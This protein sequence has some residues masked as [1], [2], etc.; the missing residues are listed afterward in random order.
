MP[1]FFDGGAGRGL[2][3]LKVAPAAQT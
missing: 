3:P 1:A 2:M